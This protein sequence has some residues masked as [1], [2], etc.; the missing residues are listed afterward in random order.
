ATSADQ[1]AG[2]TVRNHAVSW[3]DTVGPLHVH[4]DVD[5]G[6]G[7]GA[8]DGFLDA[9]D[10][11]VGV[12]GAAG[13]RGGQGADRLGLGGE[14]GAVLVAVGVG[15][16]RGV[17]DAQ[18]RLGA[19]HAG[20]VAFA[21]QHVD[22]RS[23]RVVVGHV[24]LLVVRGCGGVEAGQ[25]PRAVVV[26]VVRIDA[27]VEVLSVR[28][29]AAVGHPLPRVVSRSAVE[30]QPVSDQ[31]LDP[32]IAGLGE[33]VGD[34]VNVHAVGRVVGEVAG[35]DHADAVD[36]VPRVVIRRAGCVRGVADAA[37]AG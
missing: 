1:A 36:D 14:Q 34:P 31:V 27:D 23:L 8:A 28:V 15:P 17:G 37:V 4:I 32:R 30:D 7:E 22:N 33:L 10:E 24:I 20:L 18:R 19:G 26:A 29:A 35:G 6:V 25:V 2:T 11:L 13:D 9:G 16:Q 21:P 12:E 3:S 5:G